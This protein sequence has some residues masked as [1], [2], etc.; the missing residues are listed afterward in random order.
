[1]AFCFFFGGGLVFL[2][3][4]VLG[5]FEFGA[6]GL[7]PRDRE[8]LVIRVRVHRVEGLGLIRVQG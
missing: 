3:V 1:M 8:G 4:G 7:G 6:L 2:D 5:L